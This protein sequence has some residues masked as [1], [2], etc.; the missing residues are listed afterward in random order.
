M[1][2][3]IEK[4]KKLIQSC[5]QGS[6][7]A[8]KMFYN[9]YAPT[10]YAICLRY[11]KNTDDAQDALQDGFVKVFKNLA[12]YQFT[13]S[14]EGWLKRIFANTSIEHIRRKKYFVD[15]D[16]V[17]IQIP[18]NAAN[19][20]LNKISAED[21]M[22]LIHHLPNGYRTVFNM[23]CIDGYSHKEIAANLGISENTSKSQL[24]K[25]RKILQQWVSHWFN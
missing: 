12:N 2:T 5:I 15:V 19:L 24:F 22:N 14:F 8:Q 11:L 25:A 7:K 10:M 20:T 1:N 4:E 21:L 6:I 16:D 17:Q 13:G 9:Q 18:D 3:R 23:Y